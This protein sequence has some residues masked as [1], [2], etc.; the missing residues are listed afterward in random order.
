MRGR[1]PPFER[2]TKIV[3]GG[4]HFSRRRIRPD[5]P[6]RLAMAAHDS[7][8]ITGTGGPHAPSPGHRA[9]R[10]SPNSF[11]AWIDTLW[12]LPAS[13]PEWPDD[14]VMPEK[15]ARGRDRDVREVPRGG[16]RHQLPQ[17]DPAVQDH[18]EHRV[19][20]LRGRLRGARGRGAQ[21]A[22]CG[23]VRRQSVDNLQ[24]TARTVDADKLP[25]WARDPGRRAVRTHRATAPGRQ[26]GTLLGRP[27]RAAHIPQPLC[28]QDRPRMQR[29][30]TT[31]PSIRPIRTQ[32][33]R[34][35]H[36]S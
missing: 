7:V 8:S 5:G 34:A 19:Q 29:L 27:H 11:R 3:G 6:R 23:R 16:R 36:S 30:P 1:M 14:I 17:P 13:A 10:A 32:S 24:A 21:P 2:R 28:R 25:S 31:A 15:M 35:T 4:P 26:D 18:G 9:A 22:C 33:R 12:D 20:R